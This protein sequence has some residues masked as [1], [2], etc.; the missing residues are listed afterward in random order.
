MNKY[1]PVYAAILGVLALLLFLS[2]QISRL[3]SADISSP[4]VQILKNVNFKEESL[5]SNVWIKK[6]NSELNSIKVVSSTLR[7]ENNAQDDKANAYTLLSQKVALSKDKTYH[8][9]ISYSTAIFQP[10]SILN[11]GIQK[12]GVSSPNALIY[13]LSEA[14][15]ETTVEKYFNI[16]DNFRDNY[17]YIFLSGESTINISSISLIEL[18]KDPKVEQD[19]SSGNML[20]FSVEK[21][22]QE[23]PTPTSSIARSPETSPIASPPTSV[24]STP[25][26]SQTASA[27]PSVTSLSNISKYTFYPGWSVIGFEKNSKNDLF[28][29]NNLD[30]YQ[31][32]GGKW[33]KSSDSQ[34][35]FAQNAGALVY[36][37]NKDKKMLDPSPTDS[38]SSLTPSIG[39][40]L[41]YNS[42]DKEITD[43]SEYNFSNGKT[44]AKKYKIRQLVIEKKASSEVYIVSGNSSGVALK[45]ISFPEEAIPA[46]SVFWF[47]L[48]RL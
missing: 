38:Q 26:P 9:K 7:I 31:L 3:I 20:P 4:E 17:F 18:E 25:S 8:L 14:K 41:L 22:F 48:Y 23:T 15:D 33:I 39:W 36:S 10:S 40:N 12:N 29:S 37:S 13:P 21:A 35:I 19:A 43:D 1:F 45:K 2:P 24:S 11:F 28:E 30:A 44:L 6:A 16:D 42:S 34:S 5:N 47:Y 27:V 32:L 46:K